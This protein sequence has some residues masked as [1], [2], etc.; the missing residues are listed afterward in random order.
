M[1]V[2]QVA[3]YYGSPGGIERV[4]S[5]FCA[6]LKGEHEVEVLA[7]N[8]KFSTEE[9]FEDEVKVTRVGRVA[10]LNR[11][12]ICPTFPH[13][14]RKKNPDV[15]HLHMVNPMA[16]LSFLCS[17]IRGRALAT[18]HMDITRQ[19]FLKRLHNPFLH[20]VLD[21]LDLITVSS[22]RF[23]ETSP[24]LSKH[25]EKVRVVPF[26][27]SERRFQET[28][29]NRE[30]TEKL[31]ERYPGKVVLFVGRLI[32][33]KGILVL[34]EAMN[35]IDGTCLLIGS[36]YLENTIRASIRSHGLAN[37][38]HLIGNATDEELVAYYDRADV[39]VLPSINRTESF[40]ITQLEAMSR[41]TPVVCTEVGTGT[42]FINQ[43]GETGLVVPPGDSAAL[44][45]AV[46]RILSEKALAD[47]LSKGAVARYK[48]HFSE[49]TMW[50]K[51]R[52]V[53]AELLG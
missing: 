51:L 13:W 53:Y 29:Y 49:A 18:Y 3:H 38:V 25:M 11:M 24:V 8:R 4:V 5:Q 19:K 15:V 34:V 35:K 20:R 1:K 7:S 39:F 33:Y 6:C 45:E 21:R 52:A 28:P 14:L 22:A 42:T 50:E 46:N 23:A 17:G 10:H 37:R 12:S 40:G 43:N 9:T 41:G 32:H 36:G 31:K 16:E 47:R 48:T 26:G 2:L 27:I 30:L 44:A